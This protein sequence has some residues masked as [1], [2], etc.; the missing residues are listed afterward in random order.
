MIRGLY[1]SA[2][3]LLASQD[4]MDIIANNLANLNTTAFKQDRGVT[5]SFHN[6]LMTRLEGNSRNVIGSLG[7]GL[8]CSESYTDFTSGPMQY[9]DNRFDFAIS[10]AGFFMLESPQGPLYSRDGAFSIDQEGYLVNFN[11]YR[12]LDNQFNFIL[13]QEA[14]PNLIMV[15]DFEQAAALDKVGNNMFAATEQAGAIIEGG[16]VKQYYLEQSNVSPL[17]E[18]TKMISAIRRFE[19]NQRTVQAQDETLGKAVNEIA[20]V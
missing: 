11:G 14:D 15:V 13:A 12:V 17:R 20:Q 4:Q 19:I 6:M 18:M 2:S 9:T 1:A 10:G 5:E 8:R 3:G 7:V 16:V